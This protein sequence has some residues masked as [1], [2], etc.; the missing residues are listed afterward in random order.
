MKFKIASRFTDD[1]SNSIDSGDFSNPFLVI[2][3]KQMQLECEQP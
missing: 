1:E 3:H 2:Y